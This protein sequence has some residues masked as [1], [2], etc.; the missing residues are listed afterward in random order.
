MRV[1]LTVVVPQEFV[2]FTII[3]YVPAWKEWDIPESDWF[4][5]IT[6]ESGLPGPEFGS[7]NLIVVRV[8]L[9]VIILFGQTKRSK[10]TII[11]FCP[12]VR[13]TTGVNLRFTLGFGFT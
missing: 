7:E 13:Q 9:F 10:G 5:F 12:G 2:A 6:I 11:V 4:G 8:K 1:S 3:G